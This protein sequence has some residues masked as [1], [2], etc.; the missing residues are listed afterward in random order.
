MLVSFKVSY[1]FPLYQNLMSCEKLLAVIHSSSELLSFSTLYFSCWISC[2]QESIFLLRNMPVNKLYQMNTAKFLWDRLGASS[3][4]LFLQLHV[5]MK[6]I[7]FIQISILIIVLQ[8]NIAV[9]YLLCIIFY[10][11]RLLRDNS[12]VLSSPPILYL[13][14]CFICCP[15]SLSWQTVPCVLCRFH[16]GTIHTFFSFS[17]KYCWD[18]NLLLLS[19]FSI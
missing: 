3:P 6:M 17:S 10:C 12:F 8:C 18:D 5:C 4:S 14:L 11:G 9:L 7:I 15:L 19:W 1:E 16:C 13:L 2:H